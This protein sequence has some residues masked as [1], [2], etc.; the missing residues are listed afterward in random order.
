ML[1]QELRSPQLSAC[2][3]ED[4][5]VVQP[6]GSIEQHGTH[7]P[8][9]TDSNI[10]TE[11]VHRAAAQME[12]MLILPTLWYGLSPH[13][14]GADGTIT[15]G[16]DTYCAVI[17]DICRS[18]AHYGFTRLVLLNG[19]GGNDAILKGIVQGLYGELS[20]RLLTVTYWSLIRDEQV[21][22]VREGG[23]GSMGHAGELETS[24]QLYLRCHLVDLSEAK[25][26]PIRPRLPLLVED[27]FMPSRATLMNG[28]RLSKGPFIMGDPTRATAEK[29]EKLLNWA[30]DNLADY[31]RR[32]QALD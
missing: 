15:L 3:K 6:C 29:G 24:I 12:R 21:D 31:L 22:S 27:L 30:A 19:H 25:P 13:H 7:L 11:V 2:A 10:V 18:V 8:L 26:H 5:L 1:W 28:L 23:I 32:F 17:R 14:M 9:D 4:W 20:L 16:H